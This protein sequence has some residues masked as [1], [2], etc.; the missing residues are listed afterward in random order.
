MEVTAEATM[1]TKDTFSLKPSW[2]ISNALIGR[3]G[4]KPN[5]GSHNGFCLYGEDG[6]YYD[7]DELMRRF[8]EVAEGYT[9]G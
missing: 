5:D 3:L 2:I 9:G 4:I 8:L 1:V 7:L 6:E